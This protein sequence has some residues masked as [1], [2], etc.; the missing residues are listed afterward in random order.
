MPAPASPTAHQ[1]WSCSTHFTDLPTEPLLQAT[2]GPLESR[3]LHPGVFLHMTWG[4]VGKCVC[5]A[6]H[7]VT[8]P[9]G[10]EP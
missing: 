5:C 10:L 2:Q 6:G 8:I 1:L 4:K 9:H 3:C 7:R